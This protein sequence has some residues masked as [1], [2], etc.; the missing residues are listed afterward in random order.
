MPVLLFDNI[1][2]IDLAEGV[3]T[4][5][6]LYALSTVL[7]TFFLLCLIIPRLEKDSRRIGVMIQGIFRSNYILFGIP[8]AQ[9]LWG[10]EQLGDTAAL[11]ALLIPL[12]YVLA[13]LALEIFLGGRVNWGRILRNT[14]TNP[15]IIGAVAGLL[16]LLSGLALPKFAAVAV[17]NFG[18]VATPLALTAL[19]GGFRFAGAKNCLRPLL[20]TVTGR[21]IVMPAVWLTLAALLGFRD[22][23][24]ISL[25]PVYAS[26]VA[27]SSY[28]MAQQMGG[29]EELA[30]QHVVYSSVFSIVTMFI[31]IF[32][33]KELKLF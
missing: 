4:R 9:M 25:L 17:S 15:L 23:A 32:I 20:I 11:V 30:S 21:L 2:T 18:K 3:N 27:V 6:L 33:M 31:A 29:D 13:V 7:I 14:L 26:P 19:G 24:M 8:V 10:R 1:R 28:T 12:F 16:L 22:L 5:L